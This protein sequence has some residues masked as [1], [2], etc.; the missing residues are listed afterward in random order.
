VAITI[1]HPT[2]G[3]NAIARMF[4]DAKPPIIGR[5]QE[6]RFLLDLRTVADADEL[7]PRSSLIHPAC[8]AG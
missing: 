6:D 2:L 4:R 3:A 5:I 1:E 7:V 8:G